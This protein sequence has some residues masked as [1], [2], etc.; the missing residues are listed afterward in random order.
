MSVLRVPGLRTLSLTGFQ[1]APLRQKANHV[2]KKNEVSFRDNTFLLIIQFRKIAR[3][4]LKRLTL[5]KRVLFRE[6]EGQSDFQAE[7]II[8]SKLL[9][10]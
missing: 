8:I 1:I 3:R 7:Y 6:D 5:L 2:K 9:M 4:K 10:T